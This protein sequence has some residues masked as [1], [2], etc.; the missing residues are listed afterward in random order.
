MQCNFCGQD[1]EEPCQTTMELSE[2]A[3]FGV[4]RCETAMKNREN[5]ADRLPAVDDEKGWYA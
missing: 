5:A 4:E 3:L 2:R 1:V